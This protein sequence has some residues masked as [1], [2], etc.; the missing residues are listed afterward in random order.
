MADKDLELLCKKDFNEKDKI[1]SKK[2]FFKKGELY[3]GRI[4]DDEYGNYYIIYNKTGDDFQV[5]NA[6]Y[7]KPPTGE[8][9]FCIKDFF[10]TKAEWRDKQIDSIL[11]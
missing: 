1:F 9:N 6:D 2:V 5:F 8:N 7:E 3:K 10:Y 4:A 11:E